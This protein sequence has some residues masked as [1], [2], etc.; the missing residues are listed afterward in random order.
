MTVCSVTFLIADEHDPLFG[1]CYRPTSYLFR[2]WPYE[3]PDVLYGSKTAID[4]AVHM[5]D[6]TSCHREA[7]FRTDTQT[8]NCSLKT[9]RSNSLCFIIIVLIAVKRN[10]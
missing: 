9:R 3:L 8:S 5:A 2:L 7:N 6:S 4:D 1:I 10:H